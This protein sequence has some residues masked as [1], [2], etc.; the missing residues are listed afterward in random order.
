[1]E[2][3]KVMFEFGKTL[4]WKEVS[5]Y[6]LYSYERNCANKTKFWCAIVKNYKTA[7]MLDREF[8][9]CSNTSG[10]AII[11]MSGLK[12]DEIIQMRYDHRVSNKYTDRYEINAYVSSVDEEGLEL[13]FFD[14]LYKAVKYYHQIE[15]RTEVN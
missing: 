1:M 7:K 15:K 6:S 14:T 5:E 12:Q 10:D 3:I 4:N 13:I 8:L 9:E 2:K 11:D